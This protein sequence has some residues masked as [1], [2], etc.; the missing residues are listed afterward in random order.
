MLPP[1]YT[2]GLAAANTVDDLVV[3]GPNVGTALGC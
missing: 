1:M 3:N 2:P